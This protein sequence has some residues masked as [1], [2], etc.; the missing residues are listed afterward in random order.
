[1]WVPVPE[2]EREE[3][4]ITNAFVK[5]FTKKVGS[6]KTKLTVVA[7]LSAALARE[8]KVHHVVYTQENM[9]KPELIEVKLNVRKS[10]PFNLRLE[11]PSVP[12]VLNVMCEDAI[13]WI[14]NQKGTTKKGKPTKLMIEFKAVFTGAA[15]GVFEWLEKYGQAAGTLTLDSTAPVQQHLQEVPKK[16]KK[17]GKAAAAGEVV[18]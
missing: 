4:E 6:G 15:I 7:P 10:A 16:G 3:M 8:L 1:M 13:D 9:P 17:D 5:A 2:S 11:V 12:H 14:A 18:Q